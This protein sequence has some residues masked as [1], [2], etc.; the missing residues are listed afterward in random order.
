MENGLAEMHAQRPVQ[1]LVTRLG[2]GCGV[3]VEPPTLEVYTL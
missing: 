3:E 2:S 1:D